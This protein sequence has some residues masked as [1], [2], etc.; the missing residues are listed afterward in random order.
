MKLWEVLLGIFGAQIFYR[1]ILGSIV[2]NKYF[3]LQSCCRNGGKD[4]VEAL[5]YVI[6]DIVIYNDN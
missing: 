1:V 4:G 5:L 6:L 2:D 3:S